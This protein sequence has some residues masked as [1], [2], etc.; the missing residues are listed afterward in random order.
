[1]NTF[2]FSTN[3]LCVDNANYYLHKKIQIAFKNQFKFKYLI[4]Q[5]ANHLLNLTSYLFL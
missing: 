5:Q 2:F 3:N 1:M 4:I